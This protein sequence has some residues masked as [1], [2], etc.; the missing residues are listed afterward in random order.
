[1]H[2]KQKGRMTFEF[3]SLE[4]KVA[5]GNN[6]GLQEFALLLRTLEERKCYIGRK[7]KSTLQTGG[8][9]LHP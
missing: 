3:N 5:E 7:V 8:I 6:K 1:M 2:L 9:P 4:T